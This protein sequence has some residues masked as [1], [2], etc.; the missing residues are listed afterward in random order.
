MKHRLT[1]LA[2][3]LVSRCMFTEMAIDRAADVASSQHGCPRAQVVFESEGGDWT[4]WFNVCGRR[5]LYDTRE[6]HY[7]DIT[8][9]VE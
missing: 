8:H 1:P 7:Q 4:Y 9:T 5:R 6:A 3:L 2:F